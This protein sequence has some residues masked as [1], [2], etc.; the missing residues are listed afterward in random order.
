MKLQSVIK[1]QFRCVGATDLVIK[2]CTAENVGVVNSRLQVPRYQTKSWKR[3][4]DPADQIE[5]AGQAKTGAGQFVLG[6]ERPAR[7]SVHDHDKLEFMRGYNLKLDIDPSFDAT[8][9]T[10]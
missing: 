2:M 6:S 5:H 9:H 3:A 1:K 7:Q 8:F 4:P 10:R